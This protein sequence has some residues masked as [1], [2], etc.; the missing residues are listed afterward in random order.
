MLLLLGVSP[1]HEKQGY[2]RELVK[3]GFDM[4]KDDGFVVGVI[5]AAGKERFYRSC[6]FDVE[7]GRISDEGGDENPLKDIPGGTIFFWDNGK[8]PEGIMKYGE[9]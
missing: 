2:G 8:M 9:T 1:D 3:Y 7:D 4:A 5:S 6:G